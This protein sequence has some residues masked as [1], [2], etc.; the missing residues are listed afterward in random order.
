MEKHVDFAHM[1]RW[2]FLLGW[3]TVLGVWC[4][5]LFVPLYYA[6]GWESFSLKLWF[7]ET[8][9]MIKHTWIGYT[10]FLLLAPLA[11]LSPHR[12]WHR[13]LATR[14]TLS[15]RML[16]A[17]S[18]AAGVL[19]L[20]LLEVGLVYRDV[21]VYSVD[22]KPDMLVPIAPLPRLAGIVLL[23]FIWGH[24]IETLHSRPNK[25]LY[26]NYRMLIVILSVGLLVG[27]VGT[28]LIAKLAYPT[29][30]Q[31]VWAVPAF[32]AAQMMQISVL[33]WAMGTSVV[34]LFGIRPYY[35]FANARCMHCGYDL[36]GSL[37]LGDGT[38]P[39]CGHVIEQE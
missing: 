39:E 17:S 19:N 38:C 32:T 15:K 35:R 29:T 18:I 37:E 30:S 5:V 6:S 36:Q 25:V 34:L 12:N 14:G 21:L 11:T 28:N 10:T 8:P 31:Q 24:I 20:S 33:L 26:L 22:L 27:P 16:F 2:P 1:L 3:L 4:G 13:D 23:S 9:G 7:P